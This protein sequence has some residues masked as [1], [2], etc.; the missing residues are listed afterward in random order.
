MKRWKKILISIVVICVVIVGAGFGYAFYQLSKMSTTK[1]SKTNSDL[2]I[3]STATESNDITNI[4]LFG[5]DRRHK[6]DASRSDS[7]IVL[8][9]DQKHKKIKMSSLM[10]DIYVP[11][12]GH[13]STKMNAA[14]AYGGPQLAIK[15]INENFNLN[16][17]DY[18][19][20][21]FFD[22]QKLIDAIGGVPINVESDEVALI[23]KYM[24]E[25]A[26]LEKQSIT[27]V[28][29]SGVQN[30]SGMQAVAYSRIRYTTGDDFKRTER[31]RTVLTGMFTKV[32]SLGAS[33]FPSVV[34]KL[35][36]LT[37]T[38]MSS[39]NLMKL[40]TKVMGS[41]ITTMDQTRFPVDG[42]WTDKMINGQD[43]LVI[44]MIAATNQL[45]KYIYDD[46][47]PVSK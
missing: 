16:I 35:L 10:R 19:T 44:D 15:T 13:G 43:C 23:N 1:I 30:L 8:S 18:V 22:L 20:V 45:H 11:I 7:M 38:S 12:D 17:K 9:I 24:S 46:I 6:T 37:E 27:K 33:Q 21:D 5:V 3:S 41:N 31:Q 40:G 32:Q 25:T 14:Y 28:T 4:A 39:I 47:K 2:G 34:S 29:G 26:G 42:Y 36:P